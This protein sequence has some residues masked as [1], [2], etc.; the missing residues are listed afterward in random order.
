MSQKSYNSNGWDISRYP[1]GLRTQI[2]ISLLLLCFALTINAH[3]VNYIGDFTR[4]VSVD[5]PKYVIFDTDMGADDAWSLQMLLNAEKQLKSIK[6]LAVTT[7]HGNT[8]IENVIKNTYRI[9]DGLNRTDV[10]FLNPIS[11]LF[12][13]PFTSS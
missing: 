6:V 4:V 11:S 2:S 3:S 5:E 12:F 10:R 1:S 8:N 7:S 13:C 9:L